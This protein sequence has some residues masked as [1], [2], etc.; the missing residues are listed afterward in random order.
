MFTFLSVVPYKDSADRKFAVKDQIEAEKNAINGIWYSSDAWFDGAIM[1]IDNGY[2]AWDDG[3][4]ASVM[5]DYVS[6]KFKGSKLSYDA[7]TK[8][9]TLSTTKYSNGEKEYLTAKLVNGKLVVTSTNPDEAFYPGH[10][11]KIKSVD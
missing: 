1:W 2:W 4:S 3:T 6:G 8:V 5:D 7:D 10:Y 11:K 9:Y